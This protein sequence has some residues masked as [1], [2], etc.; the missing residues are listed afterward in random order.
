MQRMA[1]RNAVQGFLAVAFLQ[2]HKMD[3]N[4]N[5]LSTG[6]CMRPILIG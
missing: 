4:D 5:V 1:Q 6:K 2:R 3:L